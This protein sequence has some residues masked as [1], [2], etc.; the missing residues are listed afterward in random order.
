[1]FLVVPLQAIA[2]VYVAGILAATSRRI[3]VA[4]PSL[5]AGAIAG[6]AAGLAA[7]L[8]VYGLA[9]PRTIAMPA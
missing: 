6:L 9:T 8:A 3:P 5:A 7:A 2:I 1:M 4:T